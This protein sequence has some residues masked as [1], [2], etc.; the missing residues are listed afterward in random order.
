MLLV[1][2][3]IVS[4]FLFTTLLSRYLREACSGR[5]VTQGFGGLLCAAIIAAAH[6]GDDSIAMDKTKMDE[7]Q[8]EG[9]QLV[10]RELFLD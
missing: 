4:R 2:V 7:H 6:G 3:F 1:V 9:E 10:P 5:S 8:D